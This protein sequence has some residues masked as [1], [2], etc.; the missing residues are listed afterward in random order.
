MPSDSRYPAALQPLWVG[1]W[2]GEQAAVAVTRR[3]SELAPPEPETTPELAADYGELSHLADELWHVEVFAE[4]LG[5]YEQPIPAPPTWAKL[6]LEQIATGR[7]RLDL[8][9][10][11]WVIEASALFLLKT[12]V[13]Y[14]E[15]EWPALAPTFRRIWHQERGHVQVACRYLRRHLQQ[16]KQA[17]HLRSRMLEQFR[18]MR[19]T[20]RPAFIAEHLEPALP[21][22][23]ISVADY[24]QAAFE[25]SAQALR[26]VLAP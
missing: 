23:G 13:A 2:Y 14:T 10:G 6:L 25:A 8:I 24:E 4:L 26:S 3:L 17:T 1:F 18:F 7:D 9:V 22:L 12:Q 19:D 15:R 11:T 16:P 5:Q 21:I 20:I